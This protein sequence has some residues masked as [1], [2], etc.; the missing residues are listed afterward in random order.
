MQAFM[1]N[2]KPQAKKTGNETGQTTNIKR[3]IEVYT[4]EGCGSCAYTVSYLKQAGIGFTEYSTE[5]EENNHK[6]WAA[7]EAGGIETDEIGMPVIVVDGKV[8][9]NMDDLE[10]F[11]QKLVQKSG[12]VSN[13]PTNS[14]KPTN[15]T[16]NSNGNLTTAQIKEF[17]DRH[18]Y[19]R[20]EVGSEPLT[21]SN[22]LA[23]YALEWGEYLA[24]QNC[25]MEHRPRTGK[26]AQKYGENLYW[27]SGM[28]ATPIAS[29]DSWASEKSIYDKKPISHANLE[30]G[31]YTQIIWHKTTQVG[32]AI[33]KCA[34]NQYLVVCNYSPAGN[35][36]G[37]SPYKN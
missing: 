33:I 30:A 6:M 25:A 16:S 7:L 14:N 8:H 5:I 23:N 24:S 31:H 28:A 36:L 20:R 19:F 11:L 32:C 35:Y 26:W 22:E 15:Q 4:M 34:G 13:N 27:S 3:N 21:W 29:V 12:Q 37:Q 17:V 1:G 9:V 2:L 10:D 18:N